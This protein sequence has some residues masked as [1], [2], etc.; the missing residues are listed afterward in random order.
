MSQNK[1]Q[2]KRNKALKKRKANAKSLDA[3]ITVNDRKMGRMQLYLV[4]II[5]LIACFFIFYSLN[6]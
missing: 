3:D 5:S 2:L 1:K 6:R 4:G